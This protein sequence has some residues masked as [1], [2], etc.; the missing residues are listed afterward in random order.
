[1]S[2]TGTP[3]CMCCNTKAKPTAHRQSMACSLP[4]E[5]LQAYAF[6]NASSVPLPAA[7]GTTTPPLGAVGV[8]HQFR[9]PHRLARL[10]LAGEDAHAARRL[11]RR[12][13]KGPEP[14]RGFRAI[15]QC[16]R[17][18]EIGG[19]NGDITTR[20]N[21]FR[22]PRRIHGGEGGTHAAVAVLVE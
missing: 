13:L 4:G 12:P 3:A 17:P 14:G 2:A 5:A 7:G 18:L 6:T 11:H 15:R 8:L 19:A 16:H 1:M 9:N 21:F 20:E 10:V 22:A